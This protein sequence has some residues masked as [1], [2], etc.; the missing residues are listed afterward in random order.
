MTIQ[1]FALEAHA[2]VS[3]RHRHVIPVGEYGSIA[4]FGTIVCEPCLLSPHCLKIDGS[5]SCDV[6]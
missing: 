6:W 1:R 5:Q 3:L 2:A 4:G